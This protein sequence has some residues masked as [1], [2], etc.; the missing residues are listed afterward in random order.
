MTTCKSHPSP[1]PLS[2]SLKEIKSDTNY[3]PYYKAP[4][5]SR[6]LFLFHESGEDHGRAMYELVGGREMVNSMESE[7]KLL[8]T[9]HETESG[10]G[11]VVEFFDTEGNKISGIKSFLNRSGVEVSGV[12]NLLDAVKKISLWF[13]VISFIQA[14]DGTSGA[15]SYVFIWLT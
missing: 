15:L 9:F 10:S 13:T 8:F 3:K 12:I 2:V 6:A 7:A 5:S 4:G 14:T 11:K 1:R